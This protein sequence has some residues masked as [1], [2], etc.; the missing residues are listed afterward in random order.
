MSNPGST[1]SFDL[2]RARVIELALADVSAIGP[3]RKPTPEQRVHAA[4]LF[5]TLAASLA[6]AGVMR[7]L[8]ERRELTLTAG[9]AT[10]MLPDDVWDV[11]DPLVYRDSPTAVT[12]RPM[13]PL[14][15]SD[16]MLLGSRDQ[17]GTPIQYV[18][19]KALT[20][21]GEVAKVT[22][23]QVPDIT[24]ARVEYP[25]ILKV[26]DMTTDAAT[27]SFPAKWLRCLRYG[28]AVDLAPAYKVPESRVQTLLAQFERSKAECLE[29]DHERVSL[30]VV[31]FGYGP[32][33]GL[34]GGWF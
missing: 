7:F 12:R 25:A 1:G 18:V 11:N 8:Y 33:T 4:M 29:N 14:S 10:Y 13:W 31:P 30:Q 21:A 15:I 17:S 23:Y 3:G 27:P 5:E 34:G 20:S 28:L 22:F 19:E 24:D 32:P 26:R 16:Y 9:I 6:S 2:S